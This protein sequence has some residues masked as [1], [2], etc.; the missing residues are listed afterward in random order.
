LDSFLG[1]PICLGKN[2][3][4]IVGLANRPGGYSEELVDY[5]E[6]FLRTCATIIQ[7]DRDEHSRQRAERE[8]QEAKQAA[9][10]ANRAKSEFLANMSHEVR[11]PMAAVLGFS[12]M[13]LNHGLSQSERDKAIQS[14]RLNGQHLMQI[15]DDILALTK[16]E[17]QK[18]VLEY[19]PYSP[20]QIVQEV[21]SLLR[22]RASER[23][24]ALS[25]RAEGVV[26]KLAMIDPTRVRQILVNFVSNALKFTPAGG[27]V[28]V[29][30]WCLNE[31]PQA[32][33]FV[34]MSV[35]D[36]GIGI[37]REQLE[38]LF[39]PFQQADTSTTRRFGGTGLGLSI[40]MRL[41][42]AM[43]GEITVTSE[44]GRGSEFTLRIPVGISRRQ[45]GWV[46]AA[47]LESAWVSPRM[48]SD[49]TVPTRMNG[50]ILLAEDNPDI[51]T[52]VVAHL[53]S[54]GLEVEVASNGLEAVSLAQSGKFDVILMD[55]QM[56]KLDGY[57]ATSSLRQS[58]YRGPILALTAH[59]FAEDRAR[60]LKVGCTEH[61]SKPITRELLLETIA[62]YLAKR[63]QTPSTPA[64][65]PKSAVSDSQCEA[66]KCR[67]Q[68]P[69]DN[70]LNQLQRGFVSRL[71]ER[72]REIEQALADNDLTKLKS[73][74]HRTKGVGGMYGFPELS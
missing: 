42:E 32:E 13:L 31:D 9:E 61:L 52:V 35:E 56:P 43:G 10:S 37:A 59:A 46:D 12:E 45:M 1:V 50:R 28:R 66:A 26:P 70:G 23:S 19:M 67:E 39:E 4:G 33:P 68:S 29:R 27:Q 17:A 41:A 7:G 40:S 53:E 44:E 34:C 15:I 54:A 48:P 73:L 30:F 71:P 6:P 24:I 65:L 2:L 16:I 14:I 51:Q 72:A 60:C 21:L 63:D 5:L 57:G 62:R 11:T 20:W 69:A 64:A 38:R 25:V 55:M 3:V 36:T 74:A 22:V 58:G 49:T 47:E 18:L 8:L